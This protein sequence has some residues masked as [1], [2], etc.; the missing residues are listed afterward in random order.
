VSCTQ[1]L[2]V[3]FPENIDDADFNIQS[4]EYTAIVYIKPEGGCTACTMS[5]LNPWK[6]YKDVLSKHN[7]DIL[8]IISS[9]DEQNI[10]EMLKSLNITFP[11]VFDKKSK[12]KIM[13]DK[14]FQVV[15]DG[16]FVIDKNKN[17]IFTGSP[18]ANEKKWKSF[19]ELIKH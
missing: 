5:N 13:N 15:P 4:H 17:V 7:V 19:I 9:M 18:I 2:K 1:E 8:L 6:L 3:I 12:F 16:M 10:R 14:I 11:V